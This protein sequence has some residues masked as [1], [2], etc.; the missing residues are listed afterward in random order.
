MALGKAPNG[1]DPPAQSNLL[2]AR[3]GI[4]VPHR[5]AVVLQRDV[6]CFE[7]TITVLSRNEALYELHYC[8]VK[9]MCLLCE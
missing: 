4:A 6:A 5:V 2:F 9:P 7:L 8:V 3:P 1:H